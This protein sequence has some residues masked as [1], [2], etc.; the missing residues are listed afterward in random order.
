ADDPDRELARKPREKDLLAS[1]A[2]L[3]PDQE[4]VR[5][6][7]AEDSEILRQH[8]EPRAL[9][10]RLPDQRFRLREIRFDIAARNRLDRGDG[11]FHGGVRHRSL[12]DLGSAAVAGPALPPPLFATTGSD[13]L[14]VTA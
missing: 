2:F 7:R 1:V 6:P 13:Q 11:H 4:L 8:D 3:L 12:E 9:G 10:G 5:R 14:P